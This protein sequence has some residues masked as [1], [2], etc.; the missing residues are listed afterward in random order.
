MGQLKALLPWGSGERPLVA[1]Q[2]AQL[3]QTSLERIV[4]VLGHERGRLA[5]FVPDDPRFLPAY[6]PDYATGKVSSILAGVA[7]IPPEA[8]CLILGVDQ[9]R[10]A[11][12][13]A[14]TIRRHLERLA[15]LVDQP[16]RASQESQNTPPPPGAP[17]E[18]LITIG[19]YQGRRGHPVIFSS[20]ARPDLER[21]SETTQG[22]RAVLQAHADGIET[23]DTDSPLAL[24]NLNTP[25]DYAAAL[26]YAE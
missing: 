25:E 12:L 20:A 14:A 11:A 3:R 5:P 1:Y 2:I 4:V 24:V 26:R 9:P 15:A 6:N 13:V 7:Q 8:S 23:V 21:I 10:P 18:V 19:G 22:L 16:P 17:R